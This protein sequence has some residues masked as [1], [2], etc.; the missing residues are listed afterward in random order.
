MIPAFPSRHRV[1]VGRVLKRSAIRP[2]HVKD[3]VRR[4]YVTFMQ[5]LLDITDWRPDPHQPPLAPVDE[6]L[7]PYLGASLKEKRFI[8]FGGVLRK[9]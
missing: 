9:P 2:E 1:A 3:E 8:E 4:Q 5:G 7:R 6:P